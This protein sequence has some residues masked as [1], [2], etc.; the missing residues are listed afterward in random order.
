[1][2]GW[3]WSA[4]ERTLMART[5]QFLERSYSVMVQVEELE[6][7]LGPEDIDVDSRRILKEARDE[8]GLK[9]FDTFQ[10]GWSETISWWPSGRDGTNT[11]ERHG[12]NIRRHL[13]VKDGGEKTRNSR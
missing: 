9:I 10:L 4:K 5:K 7:L 3:G 8:R 6:D 1:M 2:E 11:K 12:D 13:Q